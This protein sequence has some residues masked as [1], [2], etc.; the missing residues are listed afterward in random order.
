MRDLF[1]VDI[2]DSGRRLPTARREDFTG[3]ARTLTNVLL[4][5]ERLELRWGLALWLEECPNC[6]WPHAQISINSVGEPRLY[7]HRGCELRMVEQVL[8]DLVR[9]PR[10]RAA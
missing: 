7:C 10:R 9:G 2:G 8:A 6:E 1:P 5:V 3:N 4:A